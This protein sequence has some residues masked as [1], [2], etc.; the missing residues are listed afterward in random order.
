M[1]INKA[2]QSAFENHRKGNFE[3]AESLYKKILKKQP[4]NPDVLH[5]I[6]VLSCQLSRYDS[7]IKYIEKALQL[8]PSDMASAHYNLGCAFQGKGDLDGAIVHYRKAVELKP[9]FD[10]A[11]CNLGLALE[12]KGLVNEAVDHYK[13]AI[14][15]NPSFAGAHF[16]LGHILE[17]MGRLDEAVD[18]YQKAVAFMPH[19]AE[20]HRNLGHV[21][22]QKGYLDEAIAH[23]RKAVELKP[24]FAEAHCSLG[25]ALEKKGRL[26]EAELCY[27][28]ALQI[29]PNYAIVCNNLW[30]I[31]RIKGR[32]QEAVTYLKKALQIDP[33]FYWAHFNLGTALT[34]QGLLIQGESHYRQ[35]LRIKPDLSVAYSS[36]LL[37]MNYSC[38]YTAQNVF[39]EH[40]GFEKQCAK[41][42]QQSPLDYSNDPS[43]SRRLKVGY[44]SPDFRRHSVSYFIEPVLASHNHDRFEVFSYSDVSKPD[45]V[46]ER[47]HG[48]ADQ[49]RD[50]A[51]MTDEEVAGLIQKDCID[52]LVDLAG[53][54]GHNRM[55]SFARKPAP[56]QITY[57]GYPNTTGLSAVGYRLVDSYTDPPG[58]TDQFCTEKLL[59]M[60]E[61]FL[62]F[63]PDEDSPPVGDLPALKN[64]HVTFGSF[65]TFQKVSYETIALWAGILKELPDSRLI[66]KSRGFSDQSTLNHAMAR[67]LIHGIDSERIELIARTPSFKEHLELYNQVDIGL[68][69]YPYNGTTTTC[70]AVWMGVPVITLAGNTHVSRVGTSLLSN[71]GLSG[72]IANTPD[73]YIS[74][75]VGLARDLKRLQS[76]RG[77]LRNT[78]KCSP[79]CDAKKFITHLESYYREIWET[80]CS[81][82]QEKK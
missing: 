69:T 60:P 27:H 22:Q 32:L 28:N 7:A 40:L 49:W 50:I 73:E 64:G 17:K 67:F 18:H 61:C 76:L 62:C 37:A 66:M 19:F 48:C 52:I 39:S 57:L 72:L 16:N 53:H 31:L 68:D 38:Y 3:Q 12:K 8:R 24:S 15:L 1:N 58:L 44:V 29:N 2:I 36:L 79:L 41:F 23:H 25:Y 30:S 74:L 11:H 10:D 42:S 51:G 70:E 82:M 43:R 46:T 5:M 63:L 59:R 80:W 21:L 55:L 14:A 47:L 6:G 4:G 78:M 54:T 77:N 9:S 71:V 13:K 34:D 33:S 65:N 45:T 26:D 56:V 75:A 81:Q 20:A 35:A